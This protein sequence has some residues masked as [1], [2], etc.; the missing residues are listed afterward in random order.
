MNKRLIVRWFLFVVIFICGLFLFGYQPKAKAE[1]RKI[2]QTYI[3][4][5][6]VGKIKIDGILDEPDW[7]KAR[8]INFYHLKGK[9]PQ[10]YKEAESP[11]S[12]KLLW[13]DNNLYIGIEAKDRDIWATIREHD[14][15][16]WQEDV[17]EAFFK[18]DKNKPTYFEFEFSPKNTSL[19]LMI[20][21]RSARSFEY[22]KSYESHL[23][24][25]V[26]VYGTLDDWKDI[27]EKWVLEVAIPFSAFKDITS[28]P[29]IG[30]EWSFALC[31][32]DYSVYLE[33]GVE[34]SSSAKLSKLSFHLWEDYDILLF[35]K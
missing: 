6:R 19:D 25:A 12:G 4:H 33:K 21:R 5:Q 24:S 29:K 1:E 22:M 8:A 32:Y 9:D 30:D 26:K 7:Q 3:C 27:D 17:L 15:K 18:P 31:R 35:H 20:P 16:L 10:D 13:D 11:A 28:P 34:L 2:S 14:G 23:K